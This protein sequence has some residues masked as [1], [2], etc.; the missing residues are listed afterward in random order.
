MAEE[1]RRWPRDETDS[2]PSMPNGQNGKHR[3][4]S[5]R[6]KSSA[7]AVDCSSK[8]Q[9]SERTSPISQS[10]NGFSTNNVPRDRQCRNDEKRR[11]RRRYGGLKRVT[12]AVT[13][14]STSSQDLSDCKYSVVVVE[15][16]KDVVIDRELGCMAAL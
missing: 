16:R 13:D 7:L 11:R 8:M 6:N 5:N 2:I 12:L 3:D 14:A 10:V 15:E 4:D 1:I 9:P